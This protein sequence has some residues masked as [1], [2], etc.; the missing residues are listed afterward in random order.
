MGITFAQGIILDLQKINE[1][2]RFNFLILF[3]ITLFIF[4]WVKKSSYQARHESKYC[5]GGHF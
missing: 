1:S 4:L 2:D 3:F 5:S